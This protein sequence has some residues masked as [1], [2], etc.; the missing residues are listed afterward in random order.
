MKTLFFFIA[1]ISICLGDTLSDTTSIVNYD[2]ALSLIENKYESMQEEYNMLFKTSL[3]HWEFAHYQLFPF[4]C[5][6]FDFGKDSNTIE[7]VWGKGPIIARVNDN[8]D[9]IQIGVLSYLKRNPPESLIY[10]MFFLQKN[11]KGKW[12]F[13]RVA[14]EV[15]EI[16][17]GEEYI[18]KR[19]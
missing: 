4:G 8:P 13:Y 17:S 1:L 12:Y 15:E 6:D 11:S 18:C 19:E 9:K 10:R 16:R 5:S 3:F 2:K 7:M 14:V